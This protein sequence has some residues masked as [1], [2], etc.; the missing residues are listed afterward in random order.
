MA[1]YFSEADKRVLCQAAVIAEDMTSDYYKLSHSRWLK[2]RYDIL[3]REHLRAEEVSPHALAM[4][5]RYDGRPP[6]R[7]LPSAAFDY[8]RICLQDPNILAALRRRPA[9][10]PLALL[11]YVLTHELVHI[12]RF[13]RFEARFDAGVAERAAEE[14]LVHRLTRQIL[15][16]VRCL[17]LT[18]VIDFYESQSSGGRMYA[19]L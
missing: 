13:S 2:S 11:C 19:H 5:S 17:D 10:S 15:A 9:L 1:A 14:R 12:V 18:P 7:W 16:P 8:Y 3:T 6:D 4:V